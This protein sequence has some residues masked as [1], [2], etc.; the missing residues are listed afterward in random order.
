MT[1]LSALFFALDADQTIVKTM[2]RSADLAAGGNACAA[3]LQL[4]AELARDHEGL[5]F[6]GL[7]SHERAAFFDI[8][9]L[10]AMV[11]GFEEAEAVPFFRR[12]GGSVDGVAAAARRSLDAAQNAAALEGVALWYDRLDA[13]PEKAQSR[14]SP[15]SLV[16]YDLGAGE[17][18]VRPVFFHEDFEAAAT[19]F[20]A[21]EPFGPWEPIG[22]FEGR[23]HAELTADE[24]EDA[25]EQA[26]EGGA[27]DLDE[28]RPVAAPAPAGLPGPMAVRE[29]IERELA[30]PPRSVA[31][32]LAETLLREAVS[33]LGASDQPGYAEAV[34]GEGQEA[35]RSFLRV[36]SDKRPI[37]VIETQY[38]EIAEHVARFLAK[39]LGMRLQPVGNY[40]D[41]FGS[42]FHDGGDQIIFYD[43]TVFGGD[44]DVDRLTVRAMLKSLS[45]G[46]DIGLAV[47]SNKNAMPLAF[48][49]YTDLELTLPVLVGP[50][51]DAVFATL[52][53]EEAADAPGLD[54]WTRYSLP[55]DFE[56]ATASGLTGLAAVDDLR[57]RVERR[58][59]K[60]AAQNAPRLEEIHGLGEARELADQLVLDMR[61]AIAGEIDWAEVDRG[62]LLVGPP[63]TGKTMLAKSIS[64]EAG[65]RFIS[66]SAL[67]WQASGALDS[68]LASIREFFAEAR[69]Y[70]PA[71]VFIDE[72]DAIGNRQHHQGRND[73]YTTAVVNC[74]LEE[75][76]GF[77][78]RDGVVVIA[79]SN[80]PGK[81]DPAL[82]RAGRLDQTV[83]IHHPNVEALSKI[84]AYHI[85]LIRERTP[86]EEGVDTD[87]LAR[88]TFGQTGADVEFYVRGARR[89][90]RKDRRAVTQ[91]DFL[92]EIMR[93]PLGPSGLER[94][95]KEQIRQ[96][97]I[98]EAGHA[99]IQILGPS[100]GKE[101]SYVSIIPRPDGTLGFVASFR[102]RVDMTRSDLL[103]Q[104]RVCLAGRAAEEVLL[105]PE[106]VGAGAG[107]SSHSDLSQATRLLTRLFCQ[108][109]FSQSQKLYWSD[110]DL[111]Q[112]GKQEL[113]PEIKQEIRLT[114]DAQYRE[115]LKMLQENKRL[116]TQIV[117]ALLEHQEMTG[118]DLRALVAGARR[119]WLG[120]MLPG[121]A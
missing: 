14:F 98:H 100:G 27:E 97:A 87:E 75:L 110:V 51:R 104:I 10:V 20:F 28:P 69:R 84:Y 108:H 88:M 106:K 70:A 8:E 107:G 46:R 53:G 13:V 18:C 15:F 47:V 95:T 12:F 9:A 58:L 54:E 30:P 21:E 83:T 64:R 67:E 60:K 33:R 102:D 44:F 66:G 62:M 82:K 94:M 50:A 118:P 40:Y 52:Y 4:Y 85:G 36:L 59:K 116:L 117:E 42:R 86:V 35:F 5:G 1:K 23:V 37:L 63:G 57:Q 24:V 101:I 119:G 19:G 71:I 2:R 31:A 45:T 120:G 115:C 90:A 99:L 112:A 22:L 3:V 89:R 74:V 76:Q 25:L 6:A 7:F 91:A 121:R 48:Q 55:F 49:N 105:G 81:I 113:P 93:R 16:Y 56:K 109:G 103:E 41:P 39:E 79:A 11:A 65:I 32:V 73:Y 34:Q 68:H 17:I 96:T 114:L 61:A 26:D 80:E 43:D 29:E 92:A 77:H 78:D 111:M 72:F 38:W